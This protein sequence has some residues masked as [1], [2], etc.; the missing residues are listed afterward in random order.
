MSYVNVSLPFLTFWEQQDNAGVQASSSEL[1]TWA[2][3]NM[4]I[5]VKTVPP[6]HT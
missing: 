6:L 3:K 5:P 2:L 4:A 1:G